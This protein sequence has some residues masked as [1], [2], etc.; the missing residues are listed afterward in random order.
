MK[1]L[2]IIEVPA[3]YAV[4]MPDSRQIKRKS[5]TENNIFY[6]EAIKL[7]LLLFN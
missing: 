4:H 1:I 2:I 6:E 3:I 7:I 5:A